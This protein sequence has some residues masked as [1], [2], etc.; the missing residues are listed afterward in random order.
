MVPTLDIEERRKKILDA[1]KPKTID[2]ILRKRILKGESSATRRVNLKL[3]KYN[4]SGSKIE[5]PALK[6]E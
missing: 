2:N 5:D 4:N 1:H 3:G 6:D